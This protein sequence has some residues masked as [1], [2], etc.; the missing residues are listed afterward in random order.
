MN[1][2]VVNLRK[3][4]GEEEQIVFPLTL[5]AEARKLV[6]IDISSY[7]KQYKTYIIET[8]KYNHAIRFRLSKES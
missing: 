5:R 7:W 1:E 3:H 2:F 4:F 6:R 8:A